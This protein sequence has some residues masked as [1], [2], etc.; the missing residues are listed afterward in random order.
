[1]TGGYLG[2]AAMQPPN[3]GGMGWNTGQVH[4]NILQYYPQPI[5]VFLALGLVGFFAGGLGYLMAMRSK[6]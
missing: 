2:G 1:M 4:V 5:A 6:K 3:F